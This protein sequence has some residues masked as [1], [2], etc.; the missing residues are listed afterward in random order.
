MPGH[1][2]DFIEAVRAKAD[3]RG[4]DR[5]GLDDVELGWDGSGILSCRPITGVSGPQA[6]WK[7]DGA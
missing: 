7:S 6:K 1:Y 3:E 2:R 5:T 4:I